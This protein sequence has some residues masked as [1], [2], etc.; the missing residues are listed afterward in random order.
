MLS[1]SE[2]RDQ[3]ADLCDLADQLMAQLEAAA[4][5]RRTLEA[6]LTACRKRI[7]AL[8]D[9]GQG[10]TGEQILRREG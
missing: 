3:I 7:A 9:Q 1:E 2:L 10:L 4:G 6:Q 8:E 5:E